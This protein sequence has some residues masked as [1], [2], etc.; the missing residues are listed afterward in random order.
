MFSFV[1][2]GGFLPNQPKVATLTKR[3]RQKSHFVEPDTDNLVISILLT[4]NHAFNGNV[5]Y[6]RLVVCIV[7]GSSDE[8]LC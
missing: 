8:Q 4:L 2:L 3:L 6:K 7:S 5:T 1:K